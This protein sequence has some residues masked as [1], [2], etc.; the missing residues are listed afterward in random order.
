MKIVATDL[1]GTLL[2][3]GGKVSNRDLD[4]LRMLGNQGVVRVLATGRS[5]YA[6]LR[7]IPRTFP[8]DY[9]IFSTGVG[10]M[11]WRTGEI[12]FSAQL[13]SSRVKYLV[14]ELTRHHLDFMLHKPVPDTHHFYYSATEHPISDFHERMR[15]YPDYCFPLRMDEYPESCQA[16]AFMEPDLDRF[17][18]IAA[19][20]SDYKVIRTTS[21]INGENMWVEVFDKNV[22]K[23]HALEMLASKLNVLRS[24]VMVVGNDFND[25]DMLDY[26]P[27]SYVVANA[28]EP[29]R[30]QHHVVGDA[31]SSGFSE[32]VTH[33]LNRK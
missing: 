6:I 5:F 32:A 31:A 8:I 21:P 16:L 17:D 24:D 33:F 10:V 18:R 23:G 7:N 15:H 13:S 28:A 29:L 30:L 12:I 4:T 26:T 22:S 3:H 9:L 20:L 27:H 19:S 14:K 25:V 1:D 2:P 11:D